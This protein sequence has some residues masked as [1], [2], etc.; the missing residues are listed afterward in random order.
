MASGRSRTTLKITDPKGNETIEVEV[1][2]DW[3]F[4]A[5]VWRDADGSGYPPDGG[6][7]V[8]GYGEV[9]GDP[10]PEW[11][12]DEMVQDALDDADIDFFND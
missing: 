7:E 3:W 9:S 4:D 1:A 10:L 11:I 8:T 5:G 12:T 6:T 2:Y